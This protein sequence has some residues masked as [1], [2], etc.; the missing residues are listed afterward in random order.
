[1]TNLAVASRRD[2][3]ESKLNKFPISG[4]L[5]RRG[6]GG[7]FRN[8]YSSISWLTTNK[9]ITARKI[10]PSVQHSRPAFCNQQ[11]KRVDLGLELSPNPSRPAQIQIWR[12][13]NK[14]FTRRCFLVKPRSETL[15][16][17]ESGYNLFLDVKQH[18]ALKLRENPPS[19]LSFCCRL[20]AMSCEKYSVSK[21]YM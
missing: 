15:L 21:A 1:M 17:S 20:L 11:M 4:R 12:Q 3:P 19:F 5:V 9:N 2:P 14:T 10:F 13:C 6:P 7:M 18:F 16:I 8:W